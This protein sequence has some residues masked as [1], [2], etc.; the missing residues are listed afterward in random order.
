MLPARRQRSISQRS[1]SAVITPSFTP[2]AASSC[3]TAPTVPEEPSASCQ[4]R[5]RERRECLLELGAGRHLGG[6]ECRAVEFTV[7]K[8]L[9]RQAHAADRE[10]LGAGRVQ[11]A[12]EDHFGRAAA[13]V[14][15]QPRQR[16]RIQMGHAG[17][18]Q[19]R[20]FTAGDDFDRMAQRGLGVNQE[21]V[22]VAG[23]AQGLRGHRAH[24]YRRHA[25]QALGKAVQAIQAAIARLVGEQAMAVEPGA[26]AH[27]FLHVLDAPVLAMRLSARF[28]A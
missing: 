19:A 8:V 5:W 17:E 11:A 18:D 7:G 23:L 14:D 20:L 28:R 27:G 12:A 13:D 10:R 24:L 25:L 1:P 2:L 9:L 16:A 4:C 6:A 26:Q 15:D 21:F 22:A 3:D